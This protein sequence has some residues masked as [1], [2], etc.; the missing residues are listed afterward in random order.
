MCG[1]VNGIREGK[2]GWFSDSILAMWETLW[3]TYIQVG[4][5]WVFGM[6][7]SGGD[8]VEGCN[9]YNIWVVVVLGRSFSSQCGRTSPYS[10]DW[11]ARFFQGLFYPRFNAQK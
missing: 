9:M 3:I 11:D 7:K 8:G 4:N 10:G 5:C 6:W 1:F 2:A